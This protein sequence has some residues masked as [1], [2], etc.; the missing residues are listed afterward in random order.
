MKK[1]QDVHLDILCSLTKV[2]GKKTFCVAYI[3][4]IKICYV[5][6][7]SI[8]HVFFESPKIVFFTQPIKNV[9][10][11]RNFACKHRM[12]RCTSRIFL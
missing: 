9:I 10:F 3:K 7:Y 5:K 12:L 1:I 8:K 4:N 2:C 6:S 11:L